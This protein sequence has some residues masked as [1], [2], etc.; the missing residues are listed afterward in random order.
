L[1]ARRTLKSLVADLR[2]NEFKSKKC[3]NCTIMHIFRLCGCNMMLSVTNFSALLFW[4]GYFL[5]LNTRGL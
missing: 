3:G 1:D 2:V 4:D 5:Q